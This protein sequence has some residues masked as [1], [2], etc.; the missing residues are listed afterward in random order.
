MTTKSEMIL[1]VAEK[2]GFHH[3]PRFYREKLRYLYDVEVSPALVT[4]CLGKHKRR[5]SGSVDRIKKRASA[6]LHECDQDVNLAVRLVR[7]VSRND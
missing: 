3:S 7:L 1:A 6:L 5:L 2:D 4:N